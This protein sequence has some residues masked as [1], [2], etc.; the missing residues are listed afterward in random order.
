MGL[1]SMQN[2]MV[3][4]APHIESTSGDLATFTT[5]FPARLN[6]C[7]V[8]IVSVQSGSGDPSPDN[9]R[10][11]TGWANC[12]VNHGQPI[13]PT[14]Y[15]GSR[16][17]NSTG[18]LISASSYK[19]TDYIP[20]VASTTMR[21]SYHMPS[22]SWYFTACY[23][24]SAKSHISSYQK[25]HSTDYDFIESL[26]IPATCAYVRFSLKYSYTNLAV[27]ANFSAKTIQF[28]TP[29]GTVYGG[30]LDVLSGVL[31]VDRYLYNLADY[32][33]TI[34]KPVTTGTSAYFRFNLPVVPVS[35]SS[36]TDNL[37]CDKYVYADI[38]SGT[39]AIGV[40][41]TMPSGATNRALFFRPDNASSYTTTTIMTFIRET[42][43]GL[44]ICYKVAPQT[45]QLTP[46]EVKTL[47]GQNNIWSDSGT[48]AIKYWNH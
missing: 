43:G 33:G 11:I 4:A 26:S 32:T 8:D 28:P 37:I 5:N 47:L 1:L 6:S 10:P 25:T 22:G 23:Y 24:D 30:T 3:M 46:Q 9:V 12:A 44:W 41:I 40:K 7:V 18:G 20:V 34:T 45:Y 17:D 39:S 35:S 36:S 38:K 21:V 2:A 13:N 31:T 16:L 27:Y 19:Y 29:P 15:S 42:L 48:V 14:I